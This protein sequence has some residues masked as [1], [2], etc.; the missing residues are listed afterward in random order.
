MPRSRGCRPITG[1]ELTVFGRRPP[2]P[3]PGFRGNCPSGAFHLTLLVEDATGYRNLCRLL[4]RAHAETRERP[5]T[6]LPR[7]RH[8][9]PRAPRRGLDLPL[10]MCARRRPGRPDRPRAPRG[11]PRGSA[12]DCCG[13][14]AP[15]GS[16]SRSSGRCW[17][18]DR[19]RNRRLAEL[20]EAARRSLRGDRQR[21]RPRAR[22]GRR[23]RTRSS[24]SGS[25]ERWSRPSPAAAATA[26]RR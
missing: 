1:A 14:S 7:D 11:A 5:L 13:S 20:A 3:L 25:A 2:S 21:P 23:S 19:T 6:A 10:G 22:R 15:S 4:T 8:R 18:G 17:R 24:R 9:R 12:G 26:R 16:G